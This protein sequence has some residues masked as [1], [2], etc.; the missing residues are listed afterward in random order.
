M[1]KNFKKFLAT[2]S[3][4]GIALCSTG[5]FSDY[6]KQ[7]DEVGVQPV[8]YSSDVDSTTTKKDDSTSDFDPNTV[9]KLEIPEQ[10]A[11]HL[12]ITGKKDETTTTASDAIDE[13]TTTS[14]D[15]DY[16]YTDTDVVTTAKRENRPTVTTATKAATKPVSKSTTKVVLKTTKATKPTTKATTTTTTTTTTVP[17]TEPPVVE[18]EP[19]VVEPELPP[20]G[21]YRIEDIC[22][23]FDSYNFYADKL[24]DSIIS[25][26][27]S[28]N[29]N[30]LISYNVGYGRTFMGAECCFIL[31]ALNSNYGYDE[32]ML[33]RFFKNYPYEDLINFKSFIL[34][35]ERVI[36]HFNVQIDYSK[37]TIDSSVGNFLN[38]AD[39]AYRNGQF[40]AFMEDKIVNGNAGQNIL[41][42]SGA[43]AILYSYDNGKYLNYD[44]FIAIDGMLDNNIDYI[45]G[46]VQGHSYHM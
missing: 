14:K 42:N 40:D 7:N 2:F 15:E 39:Y 23:N 4:A 26:A 8:G 45:N 28:E 44:N 21:E 25:R 22:S 16:S 38:E 33:Y 12:V 27:M 6:E 32:S 20:V 29:P 41:S 11:L 19:P 10:T 1:I 37:Y 3:A 18:T 30:T 13:V 31:Y 35:F 43:M 36:D 34:Q 24:I 17:I 9:T 5:C 46:V